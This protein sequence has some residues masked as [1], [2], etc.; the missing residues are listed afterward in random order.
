[1]T[2]VKRHQNSLREAKPAS[3][4]A[5][6]AVQVGTLIGAF[7]NLPTATMLAAEVQQARLPFGQS[8]RLFQYSVRS[9]HS[10]KVILEPSRDSA[11]VASNPSVK[12]QHTRYCHSSNLS[13]ACISI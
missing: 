6:D 2:Q 1:M 12:N 3:A 8:T 13:R 9:Q 4:S 7:L 11:L 5:H 10:L